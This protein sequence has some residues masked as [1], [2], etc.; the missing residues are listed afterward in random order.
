MK[1]VI[2]KYDTLGRLTKAKGGNN[3]WTQQYAYDRYGNRE[4]V[5]ASGVAADGSG[6]P[7]DGIAN[8]SY[9]T[10][11]NRI[12]TAGFEYDTAGNQIRGL[13]ADGVN[14]LKFE[15]DAANR[16]RLIKRDDDT[17]LQ[18]YTY[19]ATN[20]RIISYDYQSNYLTLYATVGG[21]TLSEYT[22]AVSNVPTWTK[23]YTYLGDSL[24]S[25]STLNGAGG[26]FTKYSHPDRLRTRTI[27]TTRIEIFFIRPKIRVFGQNRN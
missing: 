24:L 26:E 13:A 15:Y 8:V 20:A 14:W 22:E 6:M 11:N 2:I 19:S 16:L 3:L 1:R 9:N 12:T 21:T 10:T 27:M 25:T 7:R 23:S 4:S 5:T 17:Y 18:A